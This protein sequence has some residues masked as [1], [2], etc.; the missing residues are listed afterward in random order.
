MKMILANFLLFLSF[1][2]LVYSNQNSPFVNKLKYRSPPP[3]NG[4]KK[5]TSCKAEFD[6]GTLIDLSNYFIEKKVTTFLIY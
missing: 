1:S 4:I 5:L 6:D 3:S 2:H